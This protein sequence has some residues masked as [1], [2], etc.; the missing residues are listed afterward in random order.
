MVP[1]VAL[2]SGAVNS[3]IGP[4]NGPVGVDAVYATTSGSNIRSVSSVTSTYCEP[5]CWTPYPVPT[6]D[7]SRA[8]LAWLLDQLV[9]VQY[10]HAPDRPPCAT[11]ARC[12]KRMDDPLSSEP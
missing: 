5:T 7:S 3:S 11:R 10:C 2:G 1:S 8:E 12:A 9:P 4:L 6:P